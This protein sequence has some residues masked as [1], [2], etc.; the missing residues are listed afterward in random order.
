MAFTQIHAG[1]NYGYMQHA[2]SLTHYYPI[3]QHA[4]T[5]HQKPTTRADS[6]LSKPTSHADTHAVV[7]DISSSLR[8]TRDTICSP[9]GEKENKP[10]KKIRSVEPSAQIQAPK[11]KSNEPKLPV[12]NAQ[13]IPRSAPE[14]FTFSNCPSCNHTISPQDLAAICTGRGMC[15]SCNYHSSPRC[16]LCHH[17]YEKISKEDVCYY[18]TTCTSMRCPGRKM[19]DSWNI[20]A[21]T[22]KILAS[23]KTKKEKT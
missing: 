12:Q 16:P 5:R 4:D 10:A 17:R 2:L 23:V 19:S 11:A 3:D 7:P 18:A 15:S 1:H 21:Q 22:P 9:L 14:Y 20:D 8:F 13:I 6:R